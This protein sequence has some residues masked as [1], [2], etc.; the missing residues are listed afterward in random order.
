MSG[1]VNHLDLFSGIGGFALGLQ[2]AGGY[3]TVAFSE[4]DK[5][6]CKVLAARFP[7]VPNLGAVENVNRESIAGDIDIDIITAGFPCQDLSVAGK[8]AGLAGERSG[9]FWHV[10]RLVSELRPT[11]V[12][13]E[14]VPGLLSSNGGRDM[15]T[16][17]GAFQDCGLSV[18][19]RV[20]DARYFGLAQRRKR[21]WIVC[22]SDAERAGAVL[23]E[24]EGGAGDSAARG[25]ARPDVAY[26]LGASTGGVSGKEQQQTL[27][28]APTIDASDG[29]KWGCNQWVDSGKPI[30]VASPPP[31]ARGSRDAARLP[32]GMDGAR[33][34]ALGNAVPVP[35]VEWVGHGI[36]RE[37]TR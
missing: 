17:I 21:V 29:D 11:W 24:S 19:W 35:V 1:T 20:L 7:G 2:R 16:V 6:A 22:H 10:V 4:I 33:Y 32:A 8:R 28:V 15:G 27:V 3:Q 25:E 26:C 37:E 9:L 14:N 30:I 36:K 34:R 23:F 18:A 13:C 31:H 5:H 12:L